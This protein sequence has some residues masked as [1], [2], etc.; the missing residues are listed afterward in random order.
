MRFRVQ[1]TFVDRGGIINI[2][3][4]SLLEPIERGILKRREVRELL[5]EVEN[6]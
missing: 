1:E 4:A 6:M 3:L 2:L 5:T